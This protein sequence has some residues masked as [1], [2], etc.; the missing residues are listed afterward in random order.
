[1]SE[2]AEVM[3]YVMP[4]LPYIM[5]AIGILTILAFA[6]AITAYLFRI[7]DRKRIRY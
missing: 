3:S 7:L 6:D 1:M 5:P 4:I 2:I